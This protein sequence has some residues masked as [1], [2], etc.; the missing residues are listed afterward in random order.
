MINNALDNKKLPVYGDGRNIRDWLHVFD[1]CTAIDL[2][3]HDGKIGE[4]YNIGG[5]NEKENIEIVKIILK[6]LNRS[7]DLIEFVEDRLGHDKRY[8]ID[9]TKIK[10]E[11]GWKPKYTFEKG[12]NETIDWYLNNKK[13]L[14]EVISG[15]YISYYEKSIKPLIR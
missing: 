3:L 15:D 8:A 1:H 13:W 2:V 6:Y 9:S 14:K 4:V 5:N 10:S 12:I 11:L 7:N